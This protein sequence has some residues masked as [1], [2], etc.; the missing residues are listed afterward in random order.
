MRLRRARMVSGETPAADA[1]SLQ[2]KPWAMRSTSAR[3]AGVRL[4][5]SRKRAAKG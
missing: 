1:E 5:P 4:V 3:S 2:A